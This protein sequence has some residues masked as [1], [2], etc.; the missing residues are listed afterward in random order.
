MIAQV[1]HLS[2]GPY[3][4]W[5]L[6]PVLFALA[7]AYGIIWLMSSRHLRSEGNPPEE[8]AP[9]DYPLDRAHMAKGLV[10]LAFVIALF[11]SPLPKEVVALAAAGIHLASPKF[12]TSDLLGLIDWSV[13]VLFIGLF[14][15]TGAFASTGYGDDAVRWLAHAGVSLNA[16]PVLIPATTILSNIINNS[17]AVMLLL[18]VVDLSQPV[19]AYTLALANSFGGSLLVIGSVSNILVVQ[20]AQRCGIAIGFGAFVRLGIPVTLA[21]LGGL[22]LWV[23]L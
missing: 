20:Q 3:L 21:A 8:T 10:L 7:C 13:L 11:F 14:V 1:A 5:S 12:R 17:A 19:T 4:I 9:P 15:V 16:P 22:W 18:K 6:V 23:S 2:F